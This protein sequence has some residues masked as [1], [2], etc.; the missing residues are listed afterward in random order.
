MDLQRPDRHRL[1]G[2]GLAAT[3]ALAP[4][5]LY[6]VLWQSLGSFHLV[7]TAF[8]P[9]PVLVGHALADLL[10]GHEIRDNILVTLVRAASGLG[11]AVMT[12]VWLPLRLG[13]SQGV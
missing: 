4:I 1:S 10:T 3:R 2:M 12:G 7:D 11:L 8:L 13:R 9:T 6:L 5:V